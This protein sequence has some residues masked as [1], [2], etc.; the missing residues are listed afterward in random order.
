M[1]H[2]TGGI[3]VM[4][5]AATIAG[6]KKKEPAS[7]QT[8]TTPDS[9]ATAAP[10]ATADAGT[11]AQPVAAAPV[12][13]SRIFTDANQALKAGEYQKAAD[14]LL[15]LQQ[16]RLNDQQSQA[17]RREMVQLQGT[18][19]AAVARGDPNA[20]AAADKLRASTMR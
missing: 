4:L 3:L 13:A 12:D 7:S 19:A 5:A 6:C 20:K 16:Q 2:L 15:I 18:L 1:I 11:S 17:L 10:A 8:A 14:T 9:S